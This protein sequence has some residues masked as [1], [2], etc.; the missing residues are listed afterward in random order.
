MY[1]ARKHDFISEPKPIVSPCPGTDKYELVKTFRFIL[2]G[3]KFEIP[4]G[5]V[6]DGAS[7][8]KLFWAVTTSP[9][10]PKVLRAAMVHDYLYSIAAVS[11]LICDEVFHQILLMDGVEESLALTM[12]SA[13]RLGGESHFNEGGNVL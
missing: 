6:F 1:K 5:F 4:Y 9:Y 7:I 10:D 11:R 13:V 12:Y 8:P 2:N 3:E